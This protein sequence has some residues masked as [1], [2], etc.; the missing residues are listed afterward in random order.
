[1]IDR[2]TRKD[3]GKIWTS[4]QRFAFLL[5]VERTVAQ[6]Q[7]ELRIIPPSA[8]KAIQ[9]KSSFSLEHILKEEQITKHEITAFVNVLAKSIGEHGK[10]L[11]Y[12][13][14]SSDVLDTAL[15][16]QVAKAYQILQEDMTRLQDVLKRQAQ[17]YAQTICAGRTHGMHAQPTT[18]GFKLAGH[19]CEF[20][21]HGKRLERAIMQCR[22]CKL[23][24]AVG[25]Y[26]TLHPKVEEKVAELLNLQVESVATQVI[27]RDRHAE[28]ILALA[29]CATG[30]QRLAVELRHLQRTEVGEVF[31]GFSKGQQGSSLM[32]HKKNPIAGE[33]LTGVARLLR[34]YATSALENIA[35]WHERDISHSCVE[36]VIFPDS[37]ILVDY[38]LARLTDLLENLVVDEKRMKENMDLS[39]GQM[40]S[41]HL[42]LALVKKGLSRQQAYTLVQKISHNLKKGDDLKQGFLENS[43]TKDLLRKEQVEDIFSGRDFL[44]NMQKL[45]DKVLSSVDGSC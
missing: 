41:P 27:P 15:S 43:E 22:I 17:K 30:I 44:Q 42:L 25:T 10:Y 23:S 24:G 4:R 35:L 37:F 39:Q 8:A 1:M 5:E 33:N 38:S 20:Q 32:P 45:I 34:G 6:V 12:G 40:F 9:E 21:R 19:L 26:A 31:E 7:G 18:F 3:M 14:T 36:R 2:Y 29:Q 16:L 11:H 28:V 13:L